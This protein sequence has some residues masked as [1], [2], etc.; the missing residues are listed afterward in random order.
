MTVIANL[1]PIFLTAEKHFL[2][3][4]YFFIS[5]FHLY[6]IFFV[7]FLKFDLLN[8]RQDV[9]LL[10]YESFL[11]SK[12]EYGIIP[13]GIRNTDNF[14]PHTIPTQSITTR[15]IL[16]RSILTRINPHLN[17]ICTQILISIF[18]F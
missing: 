14:H 6:G 7:S 16:T 3:F 10:F 13:I 4:S 17:H 9:V 8:F 1:F 2:I 12:L 11:N 15:S 5:K 18:C